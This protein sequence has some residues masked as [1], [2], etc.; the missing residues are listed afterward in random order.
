M[1]RVHRASLKDARCHLGPSHA[2]PHDPQ[3]Q[4]QTQS[5]GGGKGGGKGG[6]GKS[7]HAK[8]P[9]KQKLRAEVPLAGNNSGSDNDDD[10]DL[11]LSEED[12]E[13]VREHAGAVGFLAD[14]DERSLGAQVLSRQAAEAAA[15]ERR[16][17]ARRQRQ[18]MRE[19][20]GGGDDDEAD[21]RKDKKKKAAAGGDDDASSDAEADYERLPRGL[22]STK[23]RPGGADDDDEGP[24]LP[25]KGPDGR[26]VF[27]K[28]N[29]Q[30]RR[31]QQ[32]RLLAAGDEGGG[33]D[34][35]A[36]TGPSPALV[37]A[38]DVVPSIPG[39]FVTDALDEEEAAAREEAKRREAERLAAAEKRALAEAARKRAAAVHPG[40]AA[41]AAAPDRM[42]RREVARTQLALAATQALA[43]EASTD[44][45]PAAALGSALRLLNALAADPQ[46]AY[47]ARLAQLSLLAVFRDVAPGYR[48]RLDADGGGEGGGG[49]GDGAGGG[50]GKGAAPAAAH[51]SKEVQR[52]RDYESA[53]L[54]GYQAYL[55]T[56]LA[57]ADRG[58]E[59]VALPPVQRTTKKRKNTGDDDEEE[60]DDDDDEQAEAEAAA[61]A[62]AAAAAAELEARRAGARVAVRCMSGLLTA[63][64]HFNYSSDLLRALVARMASRDAEARAAAV[65]AVGAT[66]RA[67]AAGG[68]TSRLALEAVQLVADL[69]RRRRC[70]C[71]PEVV[72]CLLDVRLEAA[73]AAASDM[74]GVDERDLSAAE[75]NRR[76]Q[77]GRMAA[78][79]ARKQALRDKRKGG[80]GGGLPDPASA[81]GEDAGGGR[82]GGRSA[83]MQ[84]AVREAGEAALVGL[85]R[86]LAEGDVH[87]ARGAAE[88]ARVQSRMV[89]AMFEIFFR[90]VKHCTAALKASAATAAAAAAAASA[91][92]AAAASAAEGGGGRKK[93]K[94]KGGNNSNDNSGG[95]AED[96]DAARL[97][98]A[99]EDQQA[100][101]PAG[102]V[103]RKFPLLAPSLQ[104]IARHAH[105]LSLEYLPDLAN[106]LQSLL[107]PPSPLPLRERLHVLDCAARALLR[108]QGEALLAVDR[109][110]L[111]RALY[112]ALLMVPLHPLH[113]ADFFVADGIGGSGGGAT[114]AS[115]LPATAEQER[116]EADAD[117]RDAVAARLHA[118]GGGGGGGAVDNDPNTTNSQHAPLPTP[119]LLVRVCEAFLLEGGRNAVDAPTL[120]AFAKRLCT[121][122]ATA[123]SPAESVTLCS[124]VVRLVRRHPRLSALLEWGEDAGAVPVGGRPYDPCCREPADA[125]ALGAA[126]WELPA[127]AARHWHPHVAGAARQA[128]ASLGGGGGG[129]GGAGGGSA[130]SGGDGG[131]AQQLSAS[132]GPLV[133]AMS[134]QELAAAYDVLRTGRFR[135]T[136]RT[137]SLRPRDGPGGGGSGKFVV[138]GQEARRRAA[139]AAVEGDGLLLSAQEL[140]GAGKPSS[141]SSSLA[142]AAAEGVA[143]HVAAARRAQRNA[144]L[145]SER[146]SLERR[147]ALFREH[148]IRREGKRQRKEE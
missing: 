9:Q 108:G 85:G 47:V 46:D 143:R 51:V 80:K 75:L 77:K 92:S 72:A 142:S 99:R 58:E 60:E 25:V 145:R 53:L 49:G 138:Q 87:D 41:I 43:A 106:A 21:R 8:K 55:K 52:L 33:N 124:L 17:Q 73:A 122:A 63:L 148:L 109:R 94:N 84:R 26:L 119:V 112:A 114:A 101:W 70:V 57:A 140:M 40:L 14:L 7:G 36:A 28:G 27:L 125:G 5:G 146:R 129:S 107:E 78:N 35:A 61:V 76:R 44:P 96:D 45:P 16:E 133:A 135:P 134:P 3:N 4:T 91:A 126:L 147:L 69:V 54:K 136:P 74:R 71:P 2:H 120:A 50:G 62:A 81:H 59:R 132:V 22:P 6:G 105:L 83:A 130:G 1:P 93:K 48:I 29:E 97:A 24:A 31:R 86:D 66:A 64:P 39:V 89:E 18:E 100:E 103:A 128:L 42:A 56:L 30:Q 19:R 67:Y 95:W 144:Q 131:S 68:A 34:A 118:A 116:A 111:L 117:A 115:L 79:A 65:A 10:D 15:Q 32:L 123:A 127:M 90:V 37:R 110:G 102:R 141:S 104:G 121:V 38:A 20:A 13:F 12:A 98:A 88:A 137:P 23:R 113:D 82:G 139:L 11:D